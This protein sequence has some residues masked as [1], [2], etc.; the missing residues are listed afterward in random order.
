MWKEKISQ[1]LDSDAVRTDS[2]E[3]N[4]RKSKK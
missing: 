1:K 2:A 4:L 3:I